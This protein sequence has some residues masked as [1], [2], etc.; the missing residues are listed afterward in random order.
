MA[1]PPPTPDDPAGSASDPAGSTEQ[2]ESVGEAEQVESVEPVESV[3]E[4]EQAEPVEQ[5]HPAGQ[6]DPAEPGTAPVHGSPGQAQ[7]G[8]AS[9]RVE[10]SHD[11]AEDPV[12]S[13][14]L[15]RRHTLLRRL[16]LVL[17]VAAGL[18]VLV[19]V[20][21]ALLGGRHHRSSGAT[22]VDQTGAGAAAGPAGGS[23]VGPG[24]GSGGGKGA[25]TGSVDPHGSVADFPGS[26][27]TSGPFAG[28]GEVAATLEASGG[29]AEHPCLLAATD[30]Q[31]RERGLMQ[32]TDPSLAG[33]AGMVFGYPAAQQEPFW[34][35]N[36]PMPLS[37]AF[38]G[39]DGRFVSSTDMAPCG[40]SVQCPNYFAAGPYTLAVEVPQG[41]LAT[42]GFGPGST[43]RLDGTC[44]AAADR[45]AAP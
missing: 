19:A 23:S 6:P 29:T 43:L 30:E 2:V 15:E 41:Q 13:A 37:I 17:F 10:D 7:P 11:A 21:G 26:V 32:V 3:G 12:L 18:L 5:A 16:S 4:A 33:H 27:L 22:P 40:D 1:P 20:L 35:R 9:V 45:A 44:P 8:A 34:M 31:H 28:F 14:A 38:Y 42:R 36:T 24:A 25:G 39:A